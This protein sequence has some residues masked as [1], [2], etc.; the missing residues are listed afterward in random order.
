MPQLAINPAT[1][2]P[3]A[4]YPETSDAAIGRALERARRAQRDWGRRSVRA[5]LP[6]LRRLARTLRAEG[7]AL[8]ALITAEMGKPIGQARAEVEKSAALC[9]YYVRHGVALLAPERPPGAPPEGEVV[10]DPLGTILAIMPWNFPVWQVLRAAV[11]ALLAGNVVLLKHA[12]NVPGCALALAGTFRRAGF[13]SGLFQT[14]LARG[15][16]MGALIADPRIHGV[17]LTGSTEVGKKVAAWA[18]AALKPA[19]L[20]LGGSDP[21]LVLADAD[22]PRAAEICAHA[23]L[24]NSGQSCVCAKRFIVERSILPQFEREF[25]A[26]MTAR[27]V[28]DPTGPATQVGPLARA[29]LRAQLQAQVDRSVAAGARVLC[30]G[31]PLPG[32]GYFYPPT[33]L[34]G[35]RPGMAAF[36]EELFG[37]V[38][39]VIPARDEAHALALANRSAFG[40]GATIFTRNR[41]RARSLVHAL[42]A[43]AVFVNDFVRSSP[44]LPF[45]GVKG[46]GFGRELG[47]WGARAF[48][49]VKTV[50]IAR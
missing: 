30:G 9:D 1:D 44:E 20:E 24:L 10:F 33:V 21:A 43:G 37:P 25:V 4:S 13:P 7:D 26:R 11:P 36:D 46:S 45:G 31:Q 35:V 41:R 3:V 39:A 23:R 19:V 27:I 49:N 34:T 28:G 15:D 17:T 16:R 18:G 32:I 6:L 8:A 14:L 48:T 12:A 29:D 40:L 42:E 50:W 38:A 5:R 47:P 22:I 2:R